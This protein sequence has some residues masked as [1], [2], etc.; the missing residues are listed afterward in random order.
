M[1]VSAL[2]Q[3]SEYYETFQHLGTAILYTFEFIGILFFGAMV[4]GLLVFGRY[5]EKAI[6]DNENDPIEKKALWGIGILFYSMMSYFTIDFIVNSNFW[7]IALIA[8]LMLIVTIVYAKPLS[9]LAWAKCVA[10]IEKI[11]EEHEGEQK[12]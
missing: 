12:A 3:S 7:Y 4:F 6:K 10:F 9:A 11:K 1:T 8:V 2:T 5:M